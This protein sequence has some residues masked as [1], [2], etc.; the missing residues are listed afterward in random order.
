[1]TTSF[2]KSFGKVV[3]IPSKWPREKVDAEDPD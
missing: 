2:A 3:N 1:M